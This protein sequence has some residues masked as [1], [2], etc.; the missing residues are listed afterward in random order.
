MRNIRTARWIE[1][2]E[3]GD[4][5][6]DVKLK[7]GQTEYTRISRP[8]IQ[9]PGL[10]DHL[11]IGGCL[12]AMLTVTVYTDGEIP[13]SSEVEV[14]GRLKG[15]DGSQP[16]N[17]VS[18]GKFY[19]DARDTTIHGQVTLTCMDKMLL[20][21]DAFP[22][23][24][25]PMSQQACAELVASYLGVT[26]DARTTINQS[27]T[28]QYP[29]SFTIREALG[30]IGAC[31]GGN[32]VLTP[33]DTL[34]L[35]P[36]INTG[37]TQ[38]IIAVLT[39]FTT[40]IPVEIKGVQMINTSNQEFTAGVTGEGGVLQ[41]LQNPEAS[42]AI[43]NALFT[44]YGGEI[45]KPYDAKGVLLDPAIE[46]GDIVNLKGS[47][48]Q[49]YDMDLSLGGS[50]RADLHVPDPAEMDSEYPYKTAFSRMQGKVDELG[51]I[52]IGARNYIRHSNTLDF[53]GDAYA[54]MFVFNGDQALLNGNNMEVLEHG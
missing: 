53:E 29:W 42:Q 13:R 9:R 54:W 30:F 40:G 44:Q 23:A 24:N 11:G 8:Q 37:T 33:D 22:M 52:N 4:F 1:L 17:W 45:Y 3:S 6:F 16:T 34:Y 41:S 43:A 21:D 28:I 36:L 48:V 51:N 50:Y 19:I 12:S 15:I 7:I 2:V 46:I 27:Y 25:W 10:A 14:L 20:L 32:W 26:L 39:S 35:I 49:I 31:N 47:V 5:I 18:F 38:D